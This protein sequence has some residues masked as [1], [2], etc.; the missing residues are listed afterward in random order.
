MTL[1]IEQVRH[2]YSGAGLETRTVL[3]IDAWTL[4]PGE[5]VLLRGISGSGKTTLL[6]IL[7]GL[8]QPTTGQ[9]WLGTQSL[10]ALREAQLDR[11]RAQNI[12][13]IFQT[14][15]LVPTITAA[16]NIEMPLVFAGHLQGTQRR[17]RAADLLQ[18]VGL[19][20]FARHRPA[21]L[22][23]GQRLRIAIARALANQPALLLADEP[24]A[25]LDSAASAS[26]MDLIQANCREHNAMLLVASHDPALNQR[27]ERT[28]DLRDGY[29]KEN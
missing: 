12:G 23:T 19:A 21:Q 9:V 18:Q 11:F 1:R 14:H 27:F 16:A 20:D 17:Q 6:N 10:Y 4:N 2:T 29:L 7:A 22:S 24:T 26:V 28:I 25:A 13:Y 15:L 5:Q 3:Q 8:L